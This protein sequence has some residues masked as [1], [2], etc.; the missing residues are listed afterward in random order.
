RAAAGLGYR[1]FDT[2]PVY[3]NEAAVGRGVRECG[4]PRD[5]VLV[6]TKLWN[7][8]QGYDAA[9]AACEASLD[10]LG[11]DQI[12]V[13]LI[14]WPVP[15]RD[16]Y[17]DTWRALVRLRDEGRVRRS[18]SLISSNPTWNASSTRPAW[19]PP[20]I[21]SNCTRNFSSVRSVLRMRGSVSSPRHG[22]RSAM[23]P[24]FPIL[25]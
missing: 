4:L 19:C 7:G 24:P 15:E 5:E 1:A 14:H 2:A 20:S 11:L 25:A 18:A 21:R 16:L 12:D 13:Y 23:A 8:N 22:V 9:L 10:R 17:C 6:T 3:R